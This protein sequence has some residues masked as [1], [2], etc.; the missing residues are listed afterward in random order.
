MAETSRG[1]L[2]ETLDNMDFDRYASYVVD[3][4][5]LL[6]MVKIIFLKKI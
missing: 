3:A 1:G 2:P 6:K 4:P 5:I